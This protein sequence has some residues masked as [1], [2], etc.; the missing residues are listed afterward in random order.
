MHHQEH[1]VLSQPGDRESMAIPRT[2]DEPI[3]PGIY[4]RQHVIPKDM[5]VTK[6]A[7]LLGIGRPALSNFLNGKAALSR[8]MASRMERTFGA[9]IE[10]LLD[11]QARYE[12][13]N[14]GT[15]RP[16]VTGRYASI[17]V[18]IR[19]ADID[20]WSVRIDAR[21]KLA[22]LLRGLGAYDR[23]R[24]HPRRFPSLRQRRA[25]R[26]GRSGGDVGADAMDSGRPLR[27]GVRLRPECN[28][29]GGQGLRRTPDV[30]SSAGATRNDV[31]LRNTTQLASERQMGEG[32][33]SSRRVEGRSSLR[34]ERPR[35]MAGTVRADAGLV[36]RADR[37]P[38]QWLP[39]AR[40]ML[41][42]LGRNLRSGPLS[43]ALRSVGSG[44]LRPIPGSG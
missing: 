22:A 37:R 21:H 32:E 26:M 39:L 4:V 20:G 10:T 8:E 36:G 19:A 12:R 41:G 15:R 16:V 6:A 28:A 5:T 38:G 44:V 13:R 18:A 30:D 1:G 11:L 27:L 7:G 24:A 17:L 14:E 31:R 23:V 29:Q 35:A 25:P 3:H 40:P 33:G 2:T 34:C 42:R 9:D 43:G